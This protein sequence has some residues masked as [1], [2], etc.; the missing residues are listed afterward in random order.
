[1]ARS[2]T[3]QRGFTLVEV[4]V[5]I[6]VLLVGVLGMVSLVDTSNAVTSKT[7]AREGGTNVARSIIE[8]SRSVRYRDLT[9]ASLLDALAG[10]PGLADHKPAVAGYTIRSRD[11]SYELTLSVCS[12]D[13][14][15]DNLGNH[16][17]QSIFC[18]DS[19]A[20]APGQSGTDR[21]PDDYKRVRVT[22]N[23]T[24]R[25]TSQSVTQTSAIINPVGG[26]GPSVTS[27][28]M[29]SPT[30]NSDPLLIESAAVTRGTFQATTSSAAAELDWSVNGDVKGKASGGPTTWTFQWDLDKPNG[31]PLYYDCTYL[32]Q[33]DAQDN[34]GRAGAP[35]AR[36]VKLN[37]R[38]PVKPDGLAGGRNGNGDWVDLEW[39]P[40]PECDLVG[41]RVYRSTSA[42]TVGTAIVCDGRS[43]T[44]L[45]P[46]QTSCLDNAAGSDLYYSVVALDTPP[47]GSPRSPEGVY[48]DQLHVSGSNL[49]P[50]APTGVT[51]CTGG[52]PS[53]NGADGQTAPS[54]TIVIGWSAASDSDGTIQFYRIY[55]DG[56]SYADRADEF[57]PDPGLAWIEPKPDGQPHT[58]YVSAVDNSYG[59]SPLSAPVTAP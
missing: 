25:S 12:L 9:A 33:A 6:F 10:R 7:K 30:S 29:T 15:Q 35:F 52:N 39:L 22:L 8:V 5:A 3:D 59:E 57:F 45:P 24:T 50:S 14:P 53:C 40:N 19:D 58:Y 28:V 17:G 20:L 54:G 26:L 51:A 2:P 37:R 46:D 23:W 27:L 38:A 47:A 32:V 21:N 41:Y 42:G 48:S 16:G 36:T 49:L 1:M 44:V 4:L 55:R 56:T 11:V 34:E 18:S 31:D 13:D 43:T